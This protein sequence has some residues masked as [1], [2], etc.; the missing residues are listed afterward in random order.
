MKIIGIDMSKDTFHAAFDETE[1]II[2]QNT[3]S[4]INEFIQEMIARGCTKNEIAIGTEA[5]GVY[6][7]LFCEKLRADGWLIKVINPLITHRL[8][9]ASLRQVKLAPAG[10]NQTT[11][12]G[13]RTQ[14]PGRGT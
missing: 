14:G 2:F 12:S 4:G 1:V 10:R 7:L 5:T 6:H 8:I 13:S 9:G 11:R 3:V